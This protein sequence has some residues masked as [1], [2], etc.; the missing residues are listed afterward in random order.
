MNLA[1]LHHQK[2]AL[3]RQAAAKVEEAKLVDI[4]YELLGMFEVM[5]VS[6]VVSVEAVKSFG[7][8]PV[9][10]DR[11]PRPLEIIVKLTPEQAGLISTFIEENV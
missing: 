1:A 5:G 7:M 4:A 9:Y 6:P 11:D 8:T 3:H 10:S 2:E